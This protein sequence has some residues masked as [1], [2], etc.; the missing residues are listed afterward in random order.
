VSDQPVNLGGN[1]FSVGCADVDDDGDMD[2][3]TSTVRHGDVGSASDVSELLVNVTPPG[4]P[5]LPFDRPGRT[6]LGLDRAHE[7]IWWDEGDNMTLASDV[8]L[9][10]RKDLWLFSSN[11]PD[12]GNHPWLW[13]QIEDG[14]FVRATDDAGAGHAS[15][16]GP[17]LFDLEGDGD[18]DMVAGTG[19]FNA[20]APTNAV[21]AYLNQVGQEQNWT[22]IRL[23]GRGQGG[24]NR[25][26]IGA[27]VLV[28]AGG[29]TRTQE[30]M[31]SWGHSNTQSGTALVFGLGTSCT[32][33][34]VEVRWPNAARDVTVIENVLANYRL[35]IAE[36]E[37]EVRY[38]IEEGE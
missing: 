18:L 16:E 35:E 22:S 2:L 38:L 29:R 33:E 1:N 26:G 21:H 13:R 7:G 28:T 5:L 20:A 14:T 27:R 3:L 8:D 6:A 11:Y 17:A 24:A 19:T 23:V 10:G 4:S 34:K 12:P 25:S 9:D 30:V 31:G 37:P 15:A 36:G 32:V